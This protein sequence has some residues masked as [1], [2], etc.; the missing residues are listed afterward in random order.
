MPKT[1]D[2]TKAPVD[3]LI[4]R[5]V[6]EKE[7]ANEFQ[8]RRH[9]QWDDN[10]TLYRNQVK[11]NRLTQRQAVNIPLMKE[12]IKTLLSKIDDA[13]TIYWKELSGDQE[14]EIILQEEWNNDFDTL[15]FEGVDIQDKKTVLLYGRGFK[16]LNWI[17]KKFSLTALDIYD[18]VIDPLTDPLDIETARYIVHQ[19]IYRSLRD[20]LASPLYDADAKK[21]LQTYML[22]SEAIIQSGK[23]KE[24]LEKKQ[25]RLK[26][27]GANTSDF[28]DFGAGDTLLNLT[29]QIFHLWD[30][31]KKDWVRYV[32]TYAND[33][34]KL[35]QVTL[36][37]ALGIDFYPYTSWGED[38]ETQ[39]I[40]SDGPADIVRVPNQVLNIWF[41][42]MI[43]NRTLSNFQMHWFDATNSKYQAQTYEPGPGRM[44]PAPGDPYKTIMPVSVSGLNDTLEQIGF[45]IKLVESGTA[46]TA[47]DKGVSEKGT[48][49]LGEVELLVGK[50]S[51]RTLS[52]TKFYRR[53]WQ[54]LAIKWYKM[55]EANTN[56]G[57]TTTLYKTSSKGVIW[58]KKISGKDWKSKAGYKPIAQT[59][60]EAESKTTKGLQVLFFLKGQFPNNQALSKII[61]KRSLDLI[62]LSSEEIREIQEAEKLTA[63]QPVEQ[64]MTKGAPTGTAVVSPEEKALQDKAQQLT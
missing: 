45:I 41:S 26:S 1:S 52:M 38:V 13:P 30:E 12:T 44:L 10:Y 57:D 11:T 39:D 64:P 6:R 48:I 60:S 29:E 9:A 22:S 36:M 5:L 51:E 14:K 54:E 62:D 27:I 50:S 35:R 18:V 61:Q 56:S 47:I 15:N 8:E 43:E 19:N 4:T 37:E 59:S 3:E 2:T 28:D 25:I 40:W 20:V 42:Q 21:K 53:S 7:V 46:A 49:T 31:K 17:N 23:N 63:I 32:V 16:K 24:E 34:I 55:K 58:P 33:T